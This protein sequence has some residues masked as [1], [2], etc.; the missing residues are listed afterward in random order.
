MSKLVLIGGGGHCKSVLDAAVQSGVWESIVITDS[1]Y[2]QKDHVLDCQIAGNDDV[3]PFLFDSGFM[4]AFIAV[5]GVGSVSIREEL[6]EKAK[7]IGFKFPIIKDV[8]SVVS[9]HAKIMEG[10]FIGK[11]VVVNADATV[12]RHC[13]INTGAIIEHECAVGDFS[14]VSVGSIICGGTHI[15]EK[16][17]VGAGSVIIQGVN[18][19]KGVVVGAGSTVISDVEDEMKV[20]GIVSGG[21][22][23]N[24]TCTMLVGGRQSLV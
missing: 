10:A 24:Q 13:I 4:D 5:G 7:K 23:E 19:G 12:G 16:S 11:N 6:A 22:I 17:F 18:L 8:T 20:K 3:L 21:S 15:G 14:H 1:S 9:P 2:P